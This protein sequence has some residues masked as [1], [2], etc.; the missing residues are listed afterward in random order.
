M[1]R[2][3]EKVA[4]SEAYE[5]VEGLLYALRINDWY[6]VRFN[7]FLEIYTRFSR[8]NILTVDPDGEENVQSKRLG[9]NLNMLFHAKIALAGTRIYFIPNFFLQ[10]D[11]YF[12]KF[13]VF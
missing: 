3:S 12:K 13:P 9:L 4:N 6:V 7:Q 10:P 8:N 2:R 11:F 1:S 5:E